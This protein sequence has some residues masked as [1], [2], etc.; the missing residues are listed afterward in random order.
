M[1]PVNVTEATDRYLYLFADCFPVKGYTRTLICDVTRKTLYFIDNSYY[2]LLMEL[3]RHT[4]G[5]VLEMLEDETDLTAF[6][7]FVNYLIEHELAT[8]ADDLSLFP[9]IQV[10]WDHPAEITNAIIDLRDKVHDFRRIFL[11]LEDFNCPHI[12]VRSYDEMSGETLTNILNAAQGTN[13]RSVQVLIKYKDGFNLNELFRVISKHT[14]GFLVFHSVPEDKLRQSRRQCTSDDVVFTDQE[15]TSCQSCG[16]INARSLYIPDLGGF[17]ENIRF[18]GCL[19]RKISI[20]EKGEIR[21]CPSLAKSYGNIADITLS[22]A[23]GRPDFRHYWHISKDLIQGCRDCEYR[24]ICTDCRA[25]V[26]DPADEYSKPAKCRYDPY[27]GEWA[28]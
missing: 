23:L 18:N 27:T 7:A 21:N 17:M 19:N 8:L 2:E 5:E 20:D 3:R 24:Y 11:E 28:E 13:I 25:Y 10:E 12:Q 9:P 22:D 26:Q 14:I 6:E 16:I 15:I 4:I 1:C